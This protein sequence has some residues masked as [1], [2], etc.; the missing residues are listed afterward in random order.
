[1]KIALTE[2]AVQRLKP[3]PAGQLDVTDKGYPGLVFRLSLGGRRTWCLFCRQGGKLRRITLGT[4]PSMGLK[5]AREAWRQAREDLQAGRDPSRRSARS[6][7][8]FLAVAEQWLKIDQAGKRTAG[9]AERIIRKYCVPLHG[10]PIGT[11][12]RRDLRELIR[13][14][15][16]DGEKVTMA[17]RVHG[18]LQRLFTWTVSEDLIEASPM[19]GLHKPGIEVKRDRVLTDEELAVVWR[20]CEALGWPFAP[21]VRLLILTGARRSEIGELKW[22]EIDGD[23]LRLPGVRTKQAV[24]HTIPLSPPARA[25]IEWLPRIADSEFV[26]TT[27]GRNPVSGWSNAKR[28]LASLEEP[29]VLHDLR[30]TVA[31]GLQRLNVNLQVIEAVLGHVSGSRSGIVGVY[32]RHSFDQEKRAALDAWGAHVMALVEG[33]SA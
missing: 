30:R 33:R 31:T 1:M 7:D 32:Q 29:W 20:G 4:Y 22:R 26:F 11:I 9:E 13:S 17:R 5:E 19:M 24:P 10:V 23:L 21:A 8:N 16:A 15:A 27:N 14:I 25:I 12:T 28:Q 2:A 3:P 6:A 18:R